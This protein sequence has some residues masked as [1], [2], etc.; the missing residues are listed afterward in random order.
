MKKMR[1]YIVVCLLLFQML[2]FA[3]KI[4]PLEKGL[5]SLNPTQIFPKNANENYIFNDKTNV[6]TCKTSIGKQ[7]E[8]LFTVE[9]T[10]AAKSHYNVQS[11]WK[12]N[13][14]IK[15]G[16]VLL[17]RFAIRTIYAKQEA[18]EAVVYFYVQEATPPYTKSVI[19]DISAGT[20][21]KTIDI[22]FVAAMDMNVNEAALCFSYAALVQKVEISD[23]QLFNFENK[24]TLSELPTTKFT[25]KGREENAI[26]RKNA[27]KNI[28]KNRTAPIVV[29]VKDAN[30][31]PIKNAT[32]QAKLIQSDFIWGTSADESLLAYDTLDA[33]NYRK[34]I[35]ELFNTAV[36]ENGFK[37]ETWQNKP[38]R[39]AE[40]MKAFD[41]LEQQGFRQR[42]HNAV[43]PAW[44][45]NAPFVKETALRDTAAFR[46]MIEEDIRSKMTAIKGRV[47]AWDIINELL[48]EREFLP[49]LPQNTP[50]E[51]YK[52]AKKIDP[53]A[54]LFINEYSMLNSVASPKN[55][56]NYLD[57]IARLRQNGA[58]IE[59]IGIQGHIGRQPRNPAQVLSDLDLFLAA[60]L[61]VQITEFD[62]NMADETLQADYTRDFLIACYS[63]QVVTGF[64]IWGFWEGAHWKKD[65]AMFRK[66]WSPKPNA[67]VWREWVTKKW[68]TNV[69]LN[70]DKNGKINTTGHLGKYEIKIT[71]NGKTETFIKQLTK[72]G[73]EIMYNAEYTN[74]K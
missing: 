21:W 69:T 45:F 4:Q 59:G 33:E 28:E 49:F 1:Y 51:W 56:S 32:V 29:N 22:G 15:K 6:G 3:Q 9:N 58:P 65:A 74:A 43:W 48:H 50:E 26:W 67:A 36:I 55:I 19:V 31:K 5:L 12:I 64:T 24:I 40:T 63:H 18:G 68:T 70:T 17:A 27:L 30:G 14:T 71:N 54:Q 60:G 73:L 53:N 52:L 44:K 16:D 20:E 2:G 61:P 38:E 11:S 46:K 10:Q 72:K 13:N 41:W 47:I 7:K 34:I 23:I 66:D 25:Y 35:K 57:T 39:K 37:A 42:G 62:I 8:I